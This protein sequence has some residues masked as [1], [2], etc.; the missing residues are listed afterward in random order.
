M[1][2]RRKNILKTMAVAAFALAAALLSVATPSAASSYTL[3]F[4]G[5]VTNANGFFPAAGKYPGTASIR[6]YF[7]NTRII[8][9]INITRFIYRYGLSK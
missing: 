4:T 1:I 8:R 7:V 9:Y 3:S 6:R 2:G 5:T